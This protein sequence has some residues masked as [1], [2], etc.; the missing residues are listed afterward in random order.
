[1][2]ANIVKEMKVSTPISKGHQAEDF[3]NEWNEEQIRSQS[4]TANR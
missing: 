2:C 3:Q 1:M 4:A